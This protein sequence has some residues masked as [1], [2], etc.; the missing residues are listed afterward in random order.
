MGRLSHT[1]KHIKEL[2]YSLF[3]EG[4]VENKQHVGGANED[5]VLEYRSSLKY[6]FQYKFSR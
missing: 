5:G 2:M 4:K 6:E 1:N 3:V